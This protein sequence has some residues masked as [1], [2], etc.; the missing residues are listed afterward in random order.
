MSHEQQE[1]FSTD[2]NSK[3]L[4]KIWFVVIEKEFGKALK[5]KKCLWMIPFGWERNDISGVD[6][7]PEES[8]IKMSWNQWNLEEN[9]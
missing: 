4:T 1:V 6:K 9:N 8:S 5:L 2:G 3:F 7:V